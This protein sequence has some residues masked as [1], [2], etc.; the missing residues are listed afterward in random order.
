MPPNPLS[1]SFSTAEI[2]ISI[3]NSYI[4]LVN[5]DAMTNLLLYDDNAL[6]D[7]TNTFL[8]NSVLEYKTSIK[9]F[10]QSFDLVVI[11]TDPI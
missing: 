5:E 9:K 8:L 11:Y 7:T 6:T 10:W 2:S 3:I 4:L 1:T